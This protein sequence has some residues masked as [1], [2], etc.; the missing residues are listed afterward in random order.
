M[1]FTSLRLAGVLIALAAA[2]PAADTL[3]F[4][5]AT[6][7]AIAVIDGWV[8]VNLHVLRAVKEETPAMRGGDRLETQDGHA[9]LLLTPGIFVRLARNSGI[10]AERLSPVESLVRVTSGSALLEVDDL[11]PSNRVVVSEGG[12]S[13]HILKAGLYRFDFAPPVVQVFKGECAVGSGVGMIHIG[14]GHQLSL[15][16]SFRLSR[17]Q[18]D[19]NDDLAKWSRTRSDYEAKSSVMMAQYASDAGWRVASSWIWNPWWGGYTWLPGSACLNFYGFTFWSPSMVFGTYP[20]RY[21]GIR[22]AAPSVITHQPLF[23][24]AGAR[25]H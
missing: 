12:G 23:Q 17:I 14:K 18:G 24:S 15:A 22:A 2:L 11:S 21:Y 13:V 10:E 25:R 4:R 6:V 5:S 8:S 7:G 20:A 3:P 9:E 19:S 1:Q 16:D